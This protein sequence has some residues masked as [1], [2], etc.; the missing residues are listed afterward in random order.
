[1]MIGLLLAV[2]VGPIPD[3]TAVPAA[4]EASVDA[5]AH[6]AMRWGNIE[7]VRPVVRA[8]YAESQ[9]QPAWSTTSGATPAAMRVIA[10]LDSA[11]TRGLDPEDYDVGVLHRWASAL[12]IATAQQR[13]D[14]DVTLSTAA[15]RYVMALAHGRVDPHWLY[16]RLEPIPTRIDDM[17]VLRQLTESTQPDVVFRGLEPTLPAYWRLIDVLAVYRRLAHQPNDDPADSV[18]ARINQIGLA[19]ERWRWLPR[20]VT[21]PWIIVNVPAFSLRALAQEGDPPL[22]MAVVDG[23]GAGHPTPMVITSISGVQFHP[24]WLVPPLIAEREIQPPARRDPGY[25]AREHYDL[26]RNDSVVPP[27]AA[28]VA[29]I[30]RGIEVRQRPGPW[31]ALGR[32]KFVMPNA[33]NVYLHD[34]PARQD[35]ARRRRDLS[36]GCIRVADPVALAELVLRGEPD[37]G[38]R[39]IDSVLAQG[40]P[41][42]VPLSR[43]IPVLVVYQTVM[44]G[45]DGSLLVYPDIYG[46]DRALGRALQA[47]YGRARDPVAR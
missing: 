43:P 25:L 38:R 41:L 18:R 6:P 32:I 22:R 34:T 17:A 23:K 39:R 29:R 13:A 16:P 19:L 21:P 3:T 28:N 30:G 44:P 46:R 33:A 37:W 31:N 7:D 2:S 47:P 8:V 26:L 4:I 5:T 36:H 11:A 40:D 24:A 12:S 15:A 9:W 45:P 14:F 20:D 27:T 1:M 42:L 35:F 10:V